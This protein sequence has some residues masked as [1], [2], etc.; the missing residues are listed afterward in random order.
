MDVPFF[1]VCKADP[2]VQSLLGGT[3]PRIYAF[4]EAPQT[5]IK[6]YAVYQWVGGEPFNML[7]CRPDADVAELQVDVYALTQ[8][9]STECAKA[10]RYAIELRSRVT[11]YRGTEREESTKLYRTGFDVT[12]LVDR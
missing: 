12:W 9:S 7:N 4:G 10:I 6:P 2:V 3:L 5:V 1:E 8:A 11:G